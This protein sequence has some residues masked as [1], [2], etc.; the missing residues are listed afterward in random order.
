MSSLAHHL[1]QAG[2]A[3]ERDKTATYLMLAAQQARAAAA[4]E[5]ALAHLENALAVCEEETGIRV[6]ELTE[7]RA[8]ALHG[9]GRS[10]EAEDNYRKAIELFEKEGAVAKAVGA[11]LALTMIQM[12]RMELAAGKRSTEWALERLGSA[13]P[14]LQMNLLSMRAVMM[15]L[16]GDAANAAG[17]LAQARALRTGTEDRRLT[18]ACDH[19]EAF[20]RLQLT[21]LEQAVTG[22]RRAAETYHAMGA[23]WAAADAEWAVG[24]DIFLGRTA[25]AA[26]Y[27]PG[28]FKRADRVGH[29]FAVW[30][31]KWLSAE[32]Y[33]CRMAG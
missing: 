11:S 3:A 13:E 2:A 24:W 14:Y 10:D 25:E 6:A 17:L 9:I 28:A 7:Q 23:L 21:Q 31:A 18:V 20:S 22:A 30:M 4:H 29:R 26:E 15:S 5:E 1:Y 16:S 32:L 19:I 33:E 12:W 8:E 27:L